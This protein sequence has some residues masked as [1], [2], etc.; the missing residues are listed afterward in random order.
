[1]PDN[2]YLALAIVFVPLSLVS[3][4][5]GV[6]VLPAIQHQT[7]DIQAWAT[8][9]EFVELFAVSRTAPGPGSMLV[10]LVGWKVAGW[11]GALITTL[12]MF[13]PSSILC[14][15]AAGAWARHEGKRWH[16]VIQS[17]LAPVG[18]GL[19]AAGVISLFRIADG[20]PA[21]WA[22]AAVTAAI[23]LAR[24]RTP[25]ILP[26][27]AAGAVFALLGLSPHA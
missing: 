2:P 21:S 7:V 25:P 10:T 20:G 23:L 15:M 17:G 18:T 24:P 11:G 12:S 9:R 26:L 1:M 4:G 16:T 13:V 8:E 14:F 3:F 5:G 27:A 6:S 19:I 22:T